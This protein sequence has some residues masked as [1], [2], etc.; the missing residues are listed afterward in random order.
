MGNVVGQDGLDTLV[1]H[2]TRVDGHIVGTRR[3][4]QRGGKDLV[5]RI[6][7]V[8]GEV[9]VEPSTQSEV[10]AQF[11]G[12]LSLRLQL[13]G[14]HCGRQGGRK[15]VTEGARVVSISQLVRLG[16]T[17]GSCPRTTQFQVVHRTPVPILEGRGRDKAQSGRRIEIIVVGDG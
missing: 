3:R 9:H 4:S 11:V 12:A 6:D 16:V 1:G 17:C 5:P 7:V 14:R 8:I 2:H 10:E 15:L 13:Q